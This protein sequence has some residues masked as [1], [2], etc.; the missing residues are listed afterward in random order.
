VTLL[1]KPGGGIAVSFYEDKPD[2]PVQGKGWELF[3]DG[4]VLHRKTGLIWHRKIGSPGIPRDGS[5]T[6]GRIFP[7]NHFSVTSTTLTISKYIQN[8]NGGIYGAD[9]VEG[10]AGHSDWRAPTVAELVSAM[11]F[12]VSA[13]PIADRDGNVTR[14]PWPREGVGGGM[15]PGEPLFLCA[16]YDDYYE[17]EFG[18]Q[19]CPVEWDV[20]GLI[21]NDENAWDYW[22][23]NQYY[24]FV[25]MFEGL[26]ARGRGGASV[27][28]VRGGPAN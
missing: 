25:G 1:G 16:W 9:P 2:A 18:I 21:T 23:D 4:T 11:D 26:S 8:L 19:R 20:Y 5:Q 3:D 15:K 10:N 22:T 13:P 14:Y 6:Y 27:W 12:R 24:F 17:T 7:D 28:P